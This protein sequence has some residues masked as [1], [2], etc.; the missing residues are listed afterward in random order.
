MVSTLRRLDAELEGRSLEAS[1]AYRAGWEAA[2]ARAKSALEAAFGESD[3]LTEPRIA[4]EVVASLPEGTNLFVSSSMPIREVDAFASPSRPPLRVF[5]NR[6]ANG[7]DGIISTALGVSAGSDR[8]TVLLTGDLAFLHDLGGL[9]T[10]HRE[11]VSLTI[12]V[13]NNDGGGI[14][15]FLPIAGTTPHFEKIFGTPHGVDLSHAARMFG[16]S[17]ERPGNASELSRALRASRGGGLHLIE[18][19]VER[20][21]NPEVHRALAARVAAGLREGASR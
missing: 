19:Q 21:I 20:G 15:S 12:V 6:G 11:G 5:C 18:V 17:F 3:R 2:D 4:R 14:F 1:A 8:P 13:V 16:A 7:I 10:A 9:L